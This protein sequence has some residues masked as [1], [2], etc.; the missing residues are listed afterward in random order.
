M[1]IPHDPKTERVEV[2]PDD[3]LG[4]VSVRLTHLPT[5]T[6]GQGVHVDPDEAA[7]LARFCITSEL[8]RLRKQAGPA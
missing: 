1:N 3:G 2:I 7:R 8:V 4:R 5:G 6:V